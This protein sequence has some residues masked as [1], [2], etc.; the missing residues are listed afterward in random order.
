MER[1]AITTNLL[2]SVLRYSNEATIYVA[3]NASTDE[4]VHVLKHEFPTIKIIQ[5]KGNYGYAKGYNEALKKC[6][7]AL[8]CISKFRHRGYRKLAGSNH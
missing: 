4:S 8:F 1:Y 5:N 2:P 3:D 7:R 6:G